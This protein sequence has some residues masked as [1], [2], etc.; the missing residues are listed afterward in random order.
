MTEKQTEFIDRMRG[1]VKKQTRLYIVG[2][3]CQLCG[4]E[5]FPVF[6]VGTPEGMIFEEDC[7]RCGEHFVVRFTT[8]M[9]VKSKSGSTWLLP[10]LVSKIRYN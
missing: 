8:D 10:H 9:S 6:E 4:K 1:Y 5:N 3:E 7:L 2:V